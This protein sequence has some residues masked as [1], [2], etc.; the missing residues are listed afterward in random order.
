MK[1]III[2]CS[3]IFISHYCQAQDTIRKVVEYDI[4]VALINAK[5]HP[6]F[7]QYS[8]D[9]GPET[10]LNELLEDIIADK[11]TLYEYPHPRANFALSSDIKRSLTP[12]EDTIWIFDPVTMEET[13]QITKEPGYSL[14]DVL[15]IRFHYIW[16][17]DKKSQALGNEKLFYGI[18]L[19]ENE[20]GKLPM[21]FLE[22]VWF[23][24]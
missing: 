19:E 21:E 4:P 9:K 16:S 17:W 11:V 22:L 24:E 2:L 14:K 23:S 15:S 10:W 7:S 5:D 1:G 3:F 6:W 20:E 8:L 12:H 13:I 18:I